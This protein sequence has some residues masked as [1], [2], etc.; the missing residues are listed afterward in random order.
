MDSNRA[1][2]RITSTSGLKLRLIGTHHKPSMEGFLKL[3][4]VH[5]AGR[6]AILVILVWILLIAGC[7]EEDRSGHG[8]VRS[9][10]S[11]GR[12][13]D[14]QDYKTTSE[15]A[16]KPEEIVVPSCD[17]AGPQPGP[18]EP[19][20]GDMHVPTRGIVQ[21]T[22]AN[23]D[24][25]GIP[26]DI[27]AS[28][29]AGIVG[30]LPAPPCDKSERPPTLCE[31]RDVDKFRLFSFDQVGAAYP[32]D[33]GT[34]SVEEVL[35]KDCRSRYVLAW[36]LTNALEA[37]FCVDALDEAL[38]QGGPEVFNT[39]QGSQFTSRGFTQVLKDHGVK[40]SQDG[41]GR[42]QDKIM[43]ERL[44]RT[45]KYEEVHLKAYAGPGEARKELG[46]YFHFYNNQ[47]PQHALGYR[48]PAEVFHGHPMAVGEEVSGRI[49]LKPRS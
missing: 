31:Q 12:I 34:E 3:A 6:A 45:V 40:I 21:V 29:P 46:P 32:S 19:R 1:N 26:V 17:N 47:R 15:P 36:R 7:A 30:N 42:Y 44:W 33:V 48:T 28:E 41:K 49:R 35:E 13:L 25:P 22:E 4:K 8:T 2:N 23:V 37:D 38:G 16:P 5:S 43:V 10:E 20:T 27:G 39:D 11:G 18:C 9:K 14:Q 24:N